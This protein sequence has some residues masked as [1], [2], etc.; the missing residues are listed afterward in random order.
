ML[1]LHGISLF[2]TNLKV[3]KE[4]ALGG[5]GDEKKAEN[6]VMGLLDESYDAI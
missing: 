1:Q 2:E 6:E 4:A 5:D 3:R